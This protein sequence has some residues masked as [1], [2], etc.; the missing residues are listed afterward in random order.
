MQ[1]ASMNA[2]DAVN[3]IRLDIIPATGP[4]ALLA[5][6]D[7]ASNTFLASLNKIFLKK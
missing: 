2:N 1:K 3:A 4:T 6:I 7:I 5:P